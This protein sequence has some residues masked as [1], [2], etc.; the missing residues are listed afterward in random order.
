[1]K[2][3]I[4]EHSSG[5]YPVVITNR[6]YDIL[7]EKITHFK[8]HKF[9]FIIDSNVDSLHSPVLSKYLKL[10]PEARKFILRAGE[11]SK[12][13]NTLNKI[14]ADLASNNYQRNTLIISIGG[15][16]TG[17]L[18]GF[19][20]SVYMRGVKLVH[21][22]TTIIA[23]A[24]SSIG[25]KTGINFNGRKNII[26][27][28]YHPE[29]V[30]TD[31]QFLKTLNENDYRSGLGE[32]IKYA[33]LSGTSFYDFVYDNFN[34]LERRD[35]EILEEVLF[36]CIRLKA[37]VVKKDERE[38]GLR[39]ILNFGHT[40]AHAFESASSFRIR[41]GDAVNAGI[42]SALHLSYIKG[43]INKND[44]NTLLKLPL[45]LK[46]AQSIKKLDKSKLYSIMQNDKK[47]TF[48]EPQFVLLM[49]PGILLI[50]INADKK[51]IFEAAKSLNVIS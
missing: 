49:E 43:L 30:I 25:G 29:F 18:A 36:H 27:S 17:D 41:H 31:P 51:E 6:V 4:V 50:D 22:P 26:G 12:S 39:K 42:I 5:K 21:I 33:F 16:V 44:L 15:G 9:Y 37:D 38:A 47:N 40:F 20:A 28:F 7:S 1:L 35:P 2:E 48:N 3:I 11:S 34:K 8:D 23:A 46:I 10:K 13:F 14:L 24:D 45:K 32:I 19:A